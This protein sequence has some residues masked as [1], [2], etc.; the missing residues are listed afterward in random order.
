MRTFTKSLSGL[1]TASALAVGLSVIAQPAFAA[2][3]G[4]ANSVHNLSA[5]GASNQ[6][7]VYC[8]TPHGSNDVVAAPLWNKSLSNDGTVPTEYN[9]YTSATLD[10]D[11]SQ[12]NL[13]VSLACLSC[14][15]GV[16]ARDNM[17]NFPGSG[18]W[19]PNNDVGIGGANNGG[20]LDI[21]GGPGSLGA[22]VINLG[23]DLSNDHP[24]GMNYC[25]AVNAAAA[26]AGTCGDDSFFSGDGVVAN[27]G[28]RYWIETDIGTPGSYQKS[29]LPLYGASGIGV[30]C[31]TCHD[32]HNAVEDI[33]F[34]RV[35]ND[36]SALC[37][38]CHDK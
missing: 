23:T 10:S 36:L 28:S 24:I 16:Q 5:S 32:P 37:L 17:I 6:I 38:T 9:V 25:A 19:V 14:H 2:V 15:D 35:S 7:C 34:L 33:T 26:A 27:L 12:A 21:I 29:D 18:L 31:A 20:T 4:V 11:T 3:G 22:N 8:H 13:S 30:E 1:L